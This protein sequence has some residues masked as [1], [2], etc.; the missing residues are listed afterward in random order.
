MPDPEQMRDRISL[1]PFHTIGNYLWVLEYSGSMAMR[2]LAMVNLVGNV[3][4]FVPLGYFLPVILKPMQ[5][6][7]RMLLFVLLLICAIELLQLMTL[8]GSCD[9]DDLLLNLPGTV[10]GWLLWKA[11]GKK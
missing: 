4:M 8:L 2:R 11:T 7:W 5:V 10:L 3:M 9:I 1:K 6:F